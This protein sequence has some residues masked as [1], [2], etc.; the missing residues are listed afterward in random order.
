MQLR[1]KLTVSELDR[2]EGR[3]LS[4]KI[5]A[6]FST[7]KEANEKCGLCHGQLG[8]IDQGIRDAGRKTLKKL[9]TAWERIEKGEIECRS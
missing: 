8:Q 1:N 9:R 4:R 5:R 7:A 3:D 2:Q 6:R